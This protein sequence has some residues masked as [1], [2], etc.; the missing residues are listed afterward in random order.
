MIKASLYCACA[1]VNICEAA[2]LQSCFFP[3]KIQPDGYMKWTAADWVYNKHICNA[4]SWNCP[5]FALAEI[6]NQSRN[7]VD[8]GLHWL[9]MCDVVYTLGA[10]FLYTSW[11]RLRLKLTYNT[12]YRRFVKLSCKAKSQYTFIATNLAYTLDRS[13]LYIAAK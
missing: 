11:G 8:K 1:E 3:N 9:P 4:S 2:F 7:F 13:Q 6:L 10:M 5:V 12:E